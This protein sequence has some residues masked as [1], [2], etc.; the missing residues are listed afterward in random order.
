MI[1]KY[2]IFVL[3]LRIHISYFRGHGSG[4]GRSDDGG[5]RQQSTKISSRCGKNG[6]RGPA[7]AEVALAA[8]AAAVAVAEAVA[9]AAAETAAAVAMVMAMAEGKTRGR[10]DWR[11][12][13]R[14]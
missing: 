3:V 9:V 10:G 6:K 4:S 7:G 2:H 1:L 5:G 8:T 14:L 11:E 13:L 12:G